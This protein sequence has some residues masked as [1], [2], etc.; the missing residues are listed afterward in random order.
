LGAWRYQVAVLAIKNNELKNYFNETISF[1]GI[2]VEEPDKREK[3]TKL[4]IKLEGSEEKALITKWHYPQYQYGDKL[5]IKGTLQEPEVFEVLKEGKPSSRPFAVAR[6][7]NYKDYLSQKRIFGLMYQPQ[8]ELLEKNQA[9][10]LKR[11]LIS[12]KN[13]LRTSLNKIM[14]M[15]QSGFLEALLFGDEGNISDEWKD[16]L[17]LTGTRHIAA[18]SGMNITILCFL[19]LDFLLFL[20]FWR[21]QSFYL[22]V[23]LISF[24]ILMI[25]A[26]ASA[27][28]AGIMAILFLTARHFGRPSAGPRIIVLTAGLMFLFNPL[29][30]KDIGFQ[31]SFLAIMG[32]VY[33]Q[34]IL[35]NL[36]KKIPDFFQARYN[37]SGTLAAQAFTLPILIYN[38]GQTSLISPITNIL[39]LP[40][41]PAITILGFVFS[42]VGIFWKGLA[43]F[44]SWP[45]WF[46]LS[47]L[48]KTIDWF[49]KISWSNLIF[50][51]IGPYFLLFC[52]FILGLI[53]WRTQQNKKLKFLKY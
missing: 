47:Y 2:V 37:L 44:L 7:F 5:K 29:V 38:F 41:L 11:F 52:Y 10:S 42:M 23:I 36:F 15:P 9:S 51:N 31:L 40:L 3:T 26:S 22:S 30:L 46:M 19:L 17:N 6:E 50:Q 8:I 48:T 1:V 35:F 43:Q 49:S 20:G 21:D 32:L 45:A 16:K 28:R 12:A 34:P 14:V 13:K 27:V 25:G 39:I 24:Y 53:V 18:V 4:T 33:L